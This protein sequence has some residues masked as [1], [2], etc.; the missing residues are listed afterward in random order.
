MSFFL[1]IAV[2]GIALG[3]EIDPA[4][5]PPLLIAIFILL[6]ITCFYVYVYYRITCLQKRRHTMSYDRIYLKCSSAQCLILIIG[7]IVC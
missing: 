4:P 2:Q 3:K 6:H 5:A 7:L 1:I